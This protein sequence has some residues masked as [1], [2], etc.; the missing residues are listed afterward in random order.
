[1]FASPQE[2]VLGKPLFFA[3][4]M[5]FAGYGLPVLVESHEG[6]PTKIE[7]NPEHPAS[8]GGTDVF[9]QAS[10]LDMYDPDRSQIVSYA[11]EIRT[12]SDFVAAIR[13]PLNSQ[14]AL[15]GRGSENS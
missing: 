7:G 9:M 10:I 8:L 13:G 15:Q 14:N 6:R 12:W 4:T 2:I 5:P 11:G 3:S 1:M